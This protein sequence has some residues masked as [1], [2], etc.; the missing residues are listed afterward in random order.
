MTAMIHACLWNISFRFTSKERDAETGLDYFLARYYSGAQGRFLSPDEFNGGPIELFSTIASNN[1]TFYADIRNPQS[2]NK[3]AYCLNN[4]LRFIDPDGHSAKE[5]EE[6]KRKKAAEEA[7]KQK[8]EQEAKEAGSWTPDKP[9]PDDPS[10]LGPDWSQN[11][12][13]KNPNGEQ[14]VNEKTGEK[15][16]FDK[17][18]PGEEGWKGKDH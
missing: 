12:K 2:L 1:P 13:H 10:G 11:T 9:L 17:A 8:S 5:E 4:P 7:A 15:V 3:Y 6:E 14:W 16:D 18:Q